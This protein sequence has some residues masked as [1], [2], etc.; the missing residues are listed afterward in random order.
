MID[1]YIQT[2]IS[3]YF[4]MKNVRVCIFISEYNENR[5]FLSFTCS[6]VSNNNLLSHCSLCLF[7]FDFYANIL[8]PIGYCDAEGGGA[9]EEI[10]FTII[11][12][13]SQGSGRLAYSSHLHDFLK[14]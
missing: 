4:G 9:Y 3:F 5:D 6:F 12:K 13:R 8:K 11:V 7:I 14:R 2:C 10:A 1:V